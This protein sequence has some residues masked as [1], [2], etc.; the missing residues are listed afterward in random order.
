MLVKKPSISNNIK[1]EQIAFHFSE[2]MKTLGLNLEDPSLKE[3]PQRVAKMY[4]DEIFQG[5]S[6][7]N[8]P[9]IST[10][11]SNSNKK[12]AHIVLVKDITINSFC[13]HHF[14]PMFGKAHIA[15]IPNTSLIGLSKINRIARFFSQ[16]PQLQERL[17]QQIADSLSA[18]LEIQDVAVYIEAKHFCVAARGV[19][20]DQ[21]LTITHE[22][23]GDFES[24]PMRRQEFFQMIK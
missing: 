23:R 8:F 13:E 1:I 16:R 9:K 4:V 5:L 22:L 14:V 19:S 6:D 20:D 24:N 15:Y 18:I 17:T 2:I 12:N 10:F 11:P 21:S 7:E 3:T